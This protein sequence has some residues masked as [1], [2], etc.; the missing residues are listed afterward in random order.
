MSPLLYLTATQVSK[1]KWSGGLWADSLRVRHF[2]FKGQALNNSILSSP[3]FTHLTPAVLVLSTGNSPCLQHEGTW[4]S[5]LSLLYVLF[6]NF[7][8]VQFWGQEGS[9]LLFFTTKFSSILMTWKHFTSKLGKVDEDMQWHCAIFLSLKSV[10][11]S[12]S[13]WGIEGLHVIRF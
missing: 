10:F 3:S 9:H 5:Y 6:G 7:L 2:I 11:N 12:L 4:R 1:G 13:I 8:S